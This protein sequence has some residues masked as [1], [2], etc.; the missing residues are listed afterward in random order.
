M[1]IRLSNRFQYG[2]TL[3]EVMVVVMI[4]GI[5]AAIVVPNIMDNPG[6]ARI[7]KAKQDIRV[8]ESQLELY[9]LD[10]FSYP[11]T[12]QGLEALVE[13]PAGTPEPKH[14]KQGGYLKRLPVDPWD[15]EYFY[16]YPGENGEFDIYSH[17]PD[18]Q[19]SDDDIG[20]WTL[21]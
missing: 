3:I 4:L 17:G 12:D 21:N 1:E 5:L 20:N 19:P 6:K 7:T 16:I 2:F 15:N 9:R 14:W 13:K 10:N 18:Q 8:L 11:S